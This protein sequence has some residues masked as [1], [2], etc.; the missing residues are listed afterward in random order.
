[1][2]YHLRLRPITL[3]LDLKVMSSSEV[4]VNKTPMIIAL[5]LSL[6]LVV[7]VLIGAKLVFHQA[8]SE[9]IAMS[10]LD[11]PDASSPECAKFLE[12]VPDN[13]LGHD[14]ATLAEPAPPGAAAW[15]SSSLEQVTLRCG[16]DI[17]LQY[18]DLATLDD[19]QGTSWLTVVDATPGSSLRT[20]YALNRDKVIAVTSDAA[21]LEQKTVTDIG[22]QLAQALDTLPLTQRPAHP[23]PLADLDIVNKNSSS[24]S[25]L[26]D[27]LPQNFSS[28]DSAEFTRTKN[29]NLPKNTAAWIAKDFEPVILRCGTNFPESYQAGAQ[30]QQINDVVWF[31]DTTVGNGTTASAW[32]AV[33]GKDVVAVSMPQVV[34]QVVLA[35]LSAQI[36][37]EIPKQK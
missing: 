8:T 13:L 24:C 14:R 22:E 25:A 35:Q 27:K 3:G 18:T 12:S 34:A 16:V 37:K 20:F 26:L 30:L 4:P 17:P 10:T 28:S 9:P 2:V 32:F 5:I 21:G 11:N 6:L 15:K 31:E 29:N 7:G 19:V 23:L 36:T 1:M 33:D